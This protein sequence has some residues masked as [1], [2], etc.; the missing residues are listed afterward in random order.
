MPLF[1]AL[2][3]LISVVVLVATPW[4][5]LH[6]FL[7][8]VAVAT[9]FSLTAGFTIAVVGKAFGSGF[10]QA[11]TSPGLAIVAAGLVWGLAEAT[12]AAG[13]FAA[14]AA[15][16]RSLGSTW[17]AALAGLIAGLAAT[18]STAFA[19]L[20][21]LLRATGSEAPAT[22][23]R[24][25]TLALAIS[26]SHG[27]LLVSPVPIA[28]A[29]ILD[30]AWSRVFLFGLPLAVLSVVV[31]TL[32]AHW[33]SAADGAPQ[34]TTPPAVTAKPRAWPATVVLV[35]TIVPL[36]LLMVQS[37]GDIPS[38]PLGGGMARE[39]VIGVG[40]PLVLLVAGVGIIV[41]G[42]LRLG[43]RLL[44]DAAWTTRILGNVAGPLLTVGA[45]GGLQRLCQETGMAELLGERLT[46]W[47]ITGFAALL[48]AFLIAATIKTLQGSSLVAAI[49]AA[50]IVQPLLIPL[51]LGGDNAKA[52]AVLAVGAGAMT[53]SHINDE[54][55][56]LVSPSTGFRPLR[57][58]G[59][60]AGGTLAQGVAVIAALLILAALVAVA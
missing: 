3:L 25:L 46:G 34:P 24:P 43:E 59:A 20:T 26:A 1:D 38:E 27:L 51:G 50:G 55:F 29:S 7:A 32:W 52:L 37:L 47:H 21:P 10:A 54:F 23:A 60:L 5:R 8:I 44:T 35:A 30:A 41:I 2:L 57:A 31:G 18:P 4:R 45:A 42:N 12:G 39:A 13:W 11:I 33:L 9:G 53:V 49:T 17:L 14:L 28:A 16:W 6:P 48:M 40:R 19:L 15:R 58:I 36:L 56:W 22:N